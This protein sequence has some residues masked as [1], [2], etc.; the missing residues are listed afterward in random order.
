MTS[1]VRT[2]VGEYLPPALFSD[3]A[4]YRKAYC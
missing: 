1:E 2:Q 4:Y 3:R